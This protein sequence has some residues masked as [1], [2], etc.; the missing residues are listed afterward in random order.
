[1]SASVRAVN[2]SKSYGKGAAAVRVFSG[3]S[4]DLGPGE[5]AAVVGPSGSGKSTLLH[6]LAGI[7]EPDSGEVE[8]FGVPLTS[9]DARKRARL[10]NE[11]VG[12]VFQFHHLLPE[13][14][15]LENVSLPLRI[16][17]LP[18][19]E[20][21][22]RAREALDRVGLDRRGEHRPAELSGGELQRAAVARAIIAKPRLLFADE[23]TGNLDR[24]NAESVFALLRALHAEN[25]GTVVLVTH[26][27][28]LA[29]RC[30]K[31]FTMSGEG[32]GNLDV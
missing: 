7:D 9:L 19:A 22:R 32:V 13:F 4:L 16:S 31:I 28:D 6:L 23:P 21:L 8:L 12:F 18:R 29:S 5:F 24:E 17:G 30:D 1:M 14:S 25:G 26:D 20:A 10:R 3:L 15:A 27:R 2:L 11:S